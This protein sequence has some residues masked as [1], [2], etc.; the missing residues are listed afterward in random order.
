MLSNFNYR[1]QIVKFSLGKSSQS[2][3]ECCSNS[4]VLTIAHV[5]EHLELLVNYLGLFENNVKS[6]EHSIL[7]QTG[8]LSSLINEM[9]A[10]VSNDSMASSPTSQLTSLVNR[11]TRETDVLEAQLTAEIRNVDEIR[12]KI[13]DPLISIER[14]FFTKFFGRHGVD[15]HQVQETIANL[16]AKLAF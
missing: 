15:S 5:A 7:F 10:A 6:T 13:D 12:R 2:K 1:F 16:Q 4:E 11:L 14:N 3:R 8:R 9:R